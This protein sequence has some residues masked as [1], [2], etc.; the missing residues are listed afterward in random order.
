MKHFAVIGLGRFGSS[1]AKTLGKKGQ[2]VIAIDKNE[3]IVHDIMESVTK[4]ACLDAID[5]KAMRSLG[6]QDVDV[7]IVGMGLDLESSILITLLL[8]DMEVPVIVC[9]AVSESHRK[10]LE[11]VGATKVVL[12][13]RDMGARIANTLISTT[14]KVIE[15]I[16]LS[17]DSSII[18]LIAPGDFVGKTLRELDMRSKYGVNVIALKRK[19]KEGEEKIN[20]VPQAND[21]VEE[22]DIL[23]V[24]GANEDIEAL[25]THG[26][27]AKE[28]GE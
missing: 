15:H 5:E 25:K 7:A 1:V 17:A 14:D 10:V 16:D 4:A 26:D 20:V 9:K 2:Q 11:K 21:V 28:S 8:K 12:P 22:G 19:A 24:F 13:E 18:E 6:V 3:E 23:V 27:I